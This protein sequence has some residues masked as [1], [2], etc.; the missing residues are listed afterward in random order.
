[1]FL[2]KN[3]FLIAGRYV[4]LVKKQYSAHPRNTEDLR[5]S[6]HSGSTPKH[7]V[8]TQEPTH[9]NKIPKT[10]IVKIKILNAKIPKIALVWLYELNI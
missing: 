9:K 4:T 8:H 2:P 7:I 10:E 3:I 5:L 1:M 6:F